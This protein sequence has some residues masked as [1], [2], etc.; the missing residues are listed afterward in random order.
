MERLGGAEISAPEH[1]TLLV[2]SEH[3]G[4]GVVEALLPGSFIRQDIS[5]RVTPRPEI[6]ALSVRA[7]VHE[8]GRAAVVPPQPNE[9][10]NG[11]D[12]SACT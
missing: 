8:L 3:P 7:H 6:V 2:D 12:V 11:H 4:T 10:A 1:N 5:D 9:V